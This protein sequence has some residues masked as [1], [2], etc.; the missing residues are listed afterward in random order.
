[1]STILTR[2]IEVESL[3]AAIAD[4]TRLRDEHRIISEDQQLIE[5]LGK[6]GFKLSVGGVSIEIYYEW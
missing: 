6:V 1:M 5:T 3:D 2:K 4:L